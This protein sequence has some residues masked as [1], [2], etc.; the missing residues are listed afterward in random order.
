VSLAGGRFRGREQIG[1]LKDFSI[2]LIFGIVIVALSLATPRFLTVTNLTNILD[3]VA[4]IGI[5]A[6]GMTMLL[7]SRNFDLS[8]G[9]QVAFIGL[10]TVKIANSH[11]LAAG[12][13]AGLCTGLAC[14]L[15]NGFVVTT[16][17]VNSLIATLGSGLIFSGLAFVLAGSSPIS[18][19]DTSFQ[20]FAIADFLG[21]P[22][23]G[24]VFIVVA[25]IT[26]WLLH[27]TVG[28]REIYAV[29]E[30]PEAARYAGVRSTRIHYFTFAYIGILCA[31]ASLLLVGQLNVADPSAASTFPLDVIAATVLGGVSIAGGKGSV[32]MAVVGV[33]LIGM[34]SNGFNLL[35]LDPNLYR[36]MTGSIIIAAVAFD[37]AVR[38]WLTTPGAVRVRARDDEEEARTTLTPGPADGST[39]S[40]RTLGGGSR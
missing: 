31:V 1:R 32:H 21:L 16:L 19:V 37:G 30:N 40:V 2:L 9:G 35:N 11:G 18:P 38:Q 24:W 17:R 25:V 20:E 8:V 3:Q 10:V 39:S 15:F 34:I 29:G 23:P 12:I 14:G 26:G 22:A 28:G 13:V 4:L 33:F 7:I 5:I 36:V 6:M 27:F